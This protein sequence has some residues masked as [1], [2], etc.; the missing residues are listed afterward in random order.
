MIPSA[1]PLQQV[2]RRVL[3]SGRYCG[4]KIKKKKRKAPKSK[5]DHFLIQ[6]RD[7]VPRTSPL[8]T[9]LGVG[10]GAQIQ[11]PRRKGGRPPPATK[12]HHT[13]S[14]LFH[15]WP[16][17]PSA[18]CSSQFA[19]KLF[20]KHNAIV[21]SQKTCTFGLIFIIMGEQ[22]YFIWGFGPHS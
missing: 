20:F 21:Q 9:N 12:I 10:T 4:L 18:I 13:T 1:V 22:K 8:P 2:Q 3:P 7:A 19:N 15:T 6:N 17:N 11:G 5:H 14:C 16:T